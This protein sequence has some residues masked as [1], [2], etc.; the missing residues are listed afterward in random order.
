MKAQ[1]V[2][3]LWGPET[4]P[5]IGNLDAYAA[6]PGSGPV[7]Q[8]CKTCAHAFRQGGTAGRY[9]KCGLVPTTRGPATDIRIRS[10]ACSKWQTANQNGDA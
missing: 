4:I 7:G 5:V 10:P 3:T 6:V 8:T 9:W 2:D 1:T